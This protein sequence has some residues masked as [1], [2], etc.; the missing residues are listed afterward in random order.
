MPIKKAQI[1]RIFVQMLAVYRQLTASA[2][3]CQVGTFDV[4]FIRLNLTQVCAQW[5]PKRLQ[6]SAPWL[7]SVC[8]SDHGNLL[9][10]SV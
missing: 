3:W 10:E 7:Y 5:K 9:H 8:Q 2:Y 6:N 1:T 4:F